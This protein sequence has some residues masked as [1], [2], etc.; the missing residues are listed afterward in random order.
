MSRIN[1]LYSILVFHSS[2]SSRD[3]L[4][5]FGNAVC[6]PKRT[7]LPPELNV[8]GFSAKD[9]ESLGLPRGRIRA[10][11]IAK[12]P[13]SLIYTE[14]GQDWNAVE[15]VRVLSRT[16]PDVW[17]SHHSAARLH[18][19][20]LPSRLLRDETLH[21]TLPMKAG[22]I[23]RKGVVGHRS[24]H[25]KMIVQFR[26]VRVS[27]PVRT[28]LELAPYLGEDELVILGDQL[29]RIPRA[30]F[31]RR[32]DPF[33]SLEAWSKLAG[34]QK[35]VKKAALLKSIEQ[36][37]VGSDSPWETRLRLAIVRAGLPEPELQVMAD[38]DDPYSPTADM[39]YRPF[40]I[41]VHYDGATHYDADTYAR[42]QRRVGTFESL[43]WRNIKCS[44]IDARNGFRDVIPEII[45]AFYFQ[46]DR[47]GRPV[48]LEIR[49]SAE[50]QG[51]AAA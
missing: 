17:M 6:M 33:I 38:P 39:G 47:L 42:D 5:R 8:S 28:V 16:F 12:S 37:R 29:V 44:A 51:L 15:S 1:V 30:R 21:V 19:L 7:P 34:S 41:A 11:D 24:R 3:E 32:T 14:T 36:V 13:V 20:F 43:S 27:S 25:Q 31:D 48:P 23:R 35:F 50:K 22:R 40:R 9:L 10:R 46:A 2:E 45:R 26:G 49:K 4:S 18:Q